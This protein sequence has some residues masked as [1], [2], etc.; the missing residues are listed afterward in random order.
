MNK[1][2]KL[3]QISPNDSLKHEQEVHGVSLRNK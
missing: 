1:I 3:N 2:Q